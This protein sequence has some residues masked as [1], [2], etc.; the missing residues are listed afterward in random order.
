[1][2]RLTWSCWR[3]IYEMI[4][5]GLNSFIPWIGNIDVYLFTSTSLIPEIKL[6]CVL[7]AFFWITCQLTP[8]SPKYTGLD[9]E[10]CIPK[11]TLDL[12]ST[13]RQTSQIWTLIYYQDSYHTIYHNWTLLPEVITSCTMALYSTVNR[14]DFGQIFTIFINIF[15]MMNWILGFIW[16]LVSTM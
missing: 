4:V 2:E 1:M 10:I 13:S 5:N 14:G 12:W 6:S 15:I 3:Q 11:L 9:M 7:W 16:G 8:V